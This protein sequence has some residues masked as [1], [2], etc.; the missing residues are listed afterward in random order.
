[1]SFVSADKNEAN[2][3]SVIVTAPASI[4]DGDILVLGGFGYKSAGGP[5]AFTYPSGFAEWATRANGNFRWGIAWKRAASETGNYTFA[6]ASATEI[7]AGIAVYRGRLASG[8]PADCISNTAYNTA[9][10]NVRAATMTIATAGSDVVWAG[11]CYDAPGTLLCPTGFT[12]RASVDT[13]D[14]L[15]M[16]DLLNQAAGATG[17]KDGTAGATVSTSKHAFMVALKPAL[18]IPPSRRLMLKC[19]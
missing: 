15:E 13:Y 12:S 11:F 5:G 10:V 16:A 7:G 1:M 2:A 8:D 9:D 18:A 17:D 4:L 19:G 3:A 14:S 6:A